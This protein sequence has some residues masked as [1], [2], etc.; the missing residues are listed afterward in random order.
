MNN[1][2]ACIFINNIVRNINTK[3]IW[4]LPVLDYT[5]ELYKRKKLPDG[6]E[7]NTDVISLF[8]L[9]QINENGLLNYCFFCC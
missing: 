9:W 7:S 5:D 2:N 1:M 8:L 6:Q 3:C 4:K